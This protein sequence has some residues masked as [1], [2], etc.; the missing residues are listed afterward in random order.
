MKITIEVLNDKLNVHADGIPD[1]DVA[2]NLLIMA[3]NAILNKPA[4]SPI[5]KPE[6]GLTMVGRR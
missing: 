1:R 6:P 5:I 4:D 3:M 2:L